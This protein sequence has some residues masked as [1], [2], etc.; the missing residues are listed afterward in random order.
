M[1]NLEIFGSITGSGLIS[2]QMVKSSFKIMGDGLRRAATQNKIS[3]NSDM[4]TADIEK[5]TDIKKIAKYR[6]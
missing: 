4:E 2:I 3:S 1:K 5:A 6:N